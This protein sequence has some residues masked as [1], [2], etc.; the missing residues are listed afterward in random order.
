MR[1]GERVDRYLILQGLS[2]AG[3]T[4]ESPAT[5]LVL[6]AES[7]EDRVLHFP[8]GDISWSERT[9]RDL[10]TIRGLSTQFL[11]AMLSGTRDS[12]GGP[13]ATSGSVQIVCWTAWTPWPRRWGIAS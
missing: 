6:D 13:P 1:P 2:P 8:R 4:R 11:P 7:L 9:H 3:E 12:A 5:F 10:K